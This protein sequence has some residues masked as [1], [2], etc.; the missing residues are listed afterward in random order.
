MK[1]LLRLAALL[2]LIWVVTLAVLR[3]DLA[4]GQATPPIATALAFSMVVCQLAFA[5]LFLLAARAPAENLAAVMT[6][7][8]LMAGKVAVD[9]YHSLVLL[10]PESA[11]LTIVD[12]VLS[13]SLLVGLLEGLPRLL[14]PSLAEE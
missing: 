4:N 11:I 13:F 14:S 6:A 10:P 1:T 3:P 7:I 8:V 9:L 2:S 5:M 12:L